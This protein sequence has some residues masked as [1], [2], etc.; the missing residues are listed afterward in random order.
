MVGHSHRTGVNP[1]LN[2]CVA[3]P[4]VIRI[5]VIRYVK[6]LILLVKLLISRVERFGTAGFPK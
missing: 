2:D 3:H 1:C 5:C 6:S 4:G